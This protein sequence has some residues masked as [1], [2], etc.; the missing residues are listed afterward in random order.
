MEDDK[1]IQMIQAVKFDGTETKLDQI[2]E[3]KE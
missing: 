1:E 3:I 2:D